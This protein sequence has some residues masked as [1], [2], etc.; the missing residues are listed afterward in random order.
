MFLDRFVRR[1]KYLSEAELLELHGLCQ[2]L[3]GPTSTQTL[4]AVAFRLGGTVLAYLCFLVWISPAVILMTLA[5]LAVS[6]FNQKQLPLSFIRF[7][8]PVAIGFMA[9]AAFTVSTRVIKGRLLYA[10]MLGSMAL[11]FLYPSPFVTPVLIISGGL[12]TG[13]VHKRKMPL[14]AQRS[15]RFSWIQAANFT[16]FFGI[17]IGAAL[18]GKFT[19]SLPIRLFENFYRNGSLIFGGGNVLVPLLFSEFVAFKHYLSEEEFLGGFALVQ[20]LPGPVFAFCSYV[21]A[22]SMRNFGWQGQLLGALAASTGIFMPG[23]LLGFFF[24]RVWNRIKG[25]RLVKAS[26]QGINAAG[27]GLMVSATLLMLQPYIKQPVMMLTV[28]ASIIV[29]YFKQI[30]PWALILAGLMAG[31]LF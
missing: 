7:M 27:A 11:A 22:L 12:I 15:L 31:L 28:L 18:V 17:I 2:I 3:P 30:P 20:V 8:V 1:G 21:G 26:L 5:A 24:I 29:L 19:G 16:I 14:K 10:I 25:Y 4:T 9:R 13:L 6:W 23:I